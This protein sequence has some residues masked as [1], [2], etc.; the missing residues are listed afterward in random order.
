M[1]HFGIS[2]TARASFYIYNKREEVDVLIE[3]LQAARD[4]CK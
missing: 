1:Q 4:V 2:A 3:G